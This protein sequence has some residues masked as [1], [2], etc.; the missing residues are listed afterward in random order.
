MAGQGKLH[1]TARGILLN[2]VSIWLAETDYLFAL[3]MHEWDGAPNGVR[4]SMVFLQ[5]VK[6]KM[7][8]VMNY[9]DNQGTVEPSAQYTVLVRPS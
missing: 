5:Q 7:W 6:K 1:G 4:C 8:R 3:L 2:M 9:V